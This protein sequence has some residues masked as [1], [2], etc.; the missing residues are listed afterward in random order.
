MKLIQIAMEE[1]KDPEDEMPKLSLEQEN[2]FKRMKLE[3]ESGAILPDFKDANMPPE[4]EGMFLDNIFNFHNAYKN[5][6]QISIFER[7]GSPEFEIAECITDAQI[8]VELDKLITILSKNGIGFETLFD[9]NERVIYEFITTELFDIEVDDIR[10]ENMMMHFVYEEFYPNNEEDIKRYCE[11]FWM[12]FLE[13]EADQ[14]FSESLISSDIKNYK[15]LKL[16]CDSF[17]SFKIIKNNP[18]NVVFDMKKK[19]A[20]ADVNL[21]FLGFLAGEKEPIVFNGVSKV[22]LKFRVGY[23]HI[24]RVGLV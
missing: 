23:W 22:K 14:E 2:E 3:L 20:T 11:E 24:S 8:T 7:I 15:E 16:F 21:N 19:I 13:V 6:K 1:N 17:T 9:Y 10:M 5:A 12:E 18:E 4:I